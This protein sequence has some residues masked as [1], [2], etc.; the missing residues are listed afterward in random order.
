[1][2]ICML[3]LLF[4]LSQLNA[5][6]QQK[7]LDSLLRTLQNHLP[8]D[9]I[10]ILILNEVVY[11]YRNIDPGKGLEYADQSIMLATKLNIPKL[12]AGAHS[13]K[14]V[15]YAARGQD[16]LA[17]LMYIKAS[18]IHSSIG[19]TIGVAVANNN[20]GLLAFNKS[21][22]RAAIDH[23][24]KSVEA[25]IAAKDTF[26]AA[27]AMT[28]LGVDYQYLS[29]FNTALGYYFKALALFELKGDPSTYGI[30]MANSLT[31]IG[32]VYK[33]ISQYERALE[34]YQRALEKNEAIE[35]PSGIAAILG[36]MASVYDL[37][38]QPQE[39][40]RLLQRAL[41]INEKIENPRGI[42]SDLANLAAAHNQLKQHG[43]ALQYVTRAI[44]MYD[45][46]EDRHYQASTRIVAADIYLDLSDKDL[47][48][49]KITNNERFAIA[50]NYL[51]HTLRTAREIEVVH[52]ERN[53]AGALARL[54]EKKKDY[55][56]A[57][58]AL[59]NY[60]RLSD[61]VMNDEKRLDIA[62]KEAAFEF[63][64]RELL[65]K[66]ETDK[67]MAFAAAAVGRHKTIRNAIAVSG[68][69]ILISAVSGLALYKRKR[70][71]DILRKEADLNAQIIDTEMKALRS[72]MNPHF[73]F[74]SLNSIRYYASVN[75]PK[76]ADE[77][78]VK[79]AT[80]M[81]QVFDNSDQ[82]KVPL[83]DDL[84]ALELYMQ[85]EAF[86]LNN[87]FTY[88]ISI[89]PD[90]DP[91]NILIPP[92]LMQPFVE[93]SIWHGLIPKEGAGNITIAISSKDEML[94][95]LIEDDGIGI[96]A[97]ET[98]GRKERPSGI[99]VTRTR[100]QLLNELDGAQARVVLKPLEKGTQVE[101]VLP[102]ECNY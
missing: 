37:Q 57:F 27:N 90:I 10:K 64:K 45:A 44:S 28:N 75:E 40:I 52:L 17:R 79:F 96:S 100:I 18:E 94:Y 61:S 41:A 89:D 97:D 26:R 77:Y 87:K 70:D 62:K 19:N 23:H 32:L 3:F 51:Q 47:A 50:E 33:N 15:S 54:Y 4:A 53:A 84:L 7:E 13:H 48:E 63:E 46:S 83:A 73:I 67:Q 22:Y 71:A 102:L 31:N 92:L 80:L 74:N 69:V 20:L 42:A 88:K 24:T 68:V 36:N 29:D 81:R 56:S 9:S 49:Q 43:Q 58:E 21:D 39:S 93:N 6:S 66:A 34:Y 91:E 8:E 30:G 38:D 99:K 59:T 65:Q 82:K 11:A 35:N 60:L 12:I 25:F 85:L 95:C 98:G 86:R 78:L 101:M 16:S 55:A 72:Q 14:G 5:S 1:M 76:L 2:R